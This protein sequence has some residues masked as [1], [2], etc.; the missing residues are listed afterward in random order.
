VRDL[1]GKVAVVTGAGSGIGLALARRFAAEHMK[2]VLA[3]VEEPAL[4]D[5][6]KGLLEQGADVLAVPTDVSLWDHVAAL[7]EATFERFG[8][9]HV[10]CNNAG[11]GPGGVTWDLAQ[12]VWDW[13]LGV[14]LF[15]VIHGIRAF[16]PRLVEQQ[17]G[18]VV[19][20]SSYVGGL[21][22]A[23]GNAP[24]CAA[25]FGV[26]GI[27]T[28]LAADLRLSGSPVKV[29]AL[30]PGGTRTRMNESGRNWPA[31]LGPP[32]PTGLRPGHPR[33]RQPA[34]PP[35]PSTAVDPS[36]VADAVLRAILDERFWVITDPNLEADIRAYVEGMLEG[37]LRL[38][39]PRS[40]GAPERVQ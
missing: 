1:A 22:G 33:R 13:V 8:T 16:V 4:A 35:G 14:D 29:T 32:P 24:Y 6:E 27:S 11:V 23:A 7:A 30:C 36:V 12:S 19:N 9:A 39:A 21:F 2:V 37:E 5:A 15:G 25:K 28:S 10:V 26:L 18:H 34:P 17:E 3:D 40:T 38:R 31:R 20:T